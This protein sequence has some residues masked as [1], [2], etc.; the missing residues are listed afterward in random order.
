MESKIKS[1]AM[2]PLSLRAEAFEAEGLAGSDLAEETARGRLFEVL[3]SCAITLVVYEGIKNSA[4]SNT[5]EIILP[6]SIPER[7]LEL[8]LF[9]FGLLV[10]NS[11]DCVM[12]G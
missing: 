2:L 8:S 4:R 3:F 11:S 9:F 7:L 1:G 5:P 10:W 6:F 12:P